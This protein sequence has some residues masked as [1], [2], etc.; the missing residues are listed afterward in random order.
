MILLV[1]GSIFIKGPIPLL[2]SVTALG[3]ILLRASRHVIYVSG[4][5]LMIV[6][7]HESS[8]PSR[9]FLV[10]LRHVHAYDTWKIATILYQINALSVIKESVNGPISSGSVLS[11][12]C[13]LRIYSRAIISSSCVNY[14]LALAQYVGSLA[15]TGHIK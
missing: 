1:Q 12:T 6:N 5:Q 4:D 8:I 11:T 9:C 14:S 13:P 2:P 15:A 10:G 7:D 3:D